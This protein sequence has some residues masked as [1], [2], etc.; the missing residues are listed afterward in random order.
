MMKNEYLEPLG[1]AM[2]LPEGYEVA[3]CRTDENT[4]RLFNITKEIEKELES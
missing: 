4:K 1:V 2:R 3:D